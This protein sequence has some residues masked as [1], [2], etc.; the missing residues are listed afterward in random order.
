MRG[1]EQNSLILPCPPILTYRVSTVT[2]VLSTVAGQDTR[3]ESLRKSGFT[4][5]KSSSSSLAETAATIT[6]DRPSQPVA[7]STDFV[8]VEKE[9]VEGAEEQ[10]GGTKG[11]GEQE[12][13]G[14]TK[15]EGEGSLNG[16]AGQSSGE[17][18]TG[19]VVGNNS[20]SP[21]KEGH[22]TPDEAS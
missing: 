3:A 1:A 16:E 8:M 5:S 15:G 7:D 21:I 19:G 17:T 12:Q 20:L 22:V 14:D 18:E 9:D 6:N 2:I 4:E 11:E 10:P 13:P